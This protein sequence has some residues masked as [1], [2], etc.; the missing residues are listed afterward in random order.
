MRPQLAQTLR[1][2][3]LALLA[4]AVALGYGLLFL[5]SFELQVVR[6]DALR[7]RQLRQ[8]AREEVLPGQRG[9]VLDR[10]GV[11][12]GTSAWRYQ[13]LAETASLAAPE[14][15]RIAAELAS[16]TGESSARLAQRMA[17]E[18]PLVRLVY[19]LHEPEVAQLRAKQLPHLRI[20]RIRLRAY[21]THEGPLPP[22]APAYTG[23][24]G[25][26]GKGLSGVELA[27]D[28]VL[29]GRSH[30]QAVRRDGRRR[31]M[32]DAYSSVDDRTGQAVH[33]TLDAR[34][35]LE[36]ERALA[37]ALERT[38]GQAASL[39]AIDPRNGDVLVSAE[40][41]SFDSNAFWNE[42]P[43]RFRARAWTDEFE[44]GSTLKP[45]VAALALDAGVIGLDEEIDC[46]EGRLQI[47]RN[48]IRDLEPHG[49]LR[50]ADA[51]RVSSNIAA[52]RLGERLGARALV[53]G[54]RR[55]GFGQSRGEVFPGAA[56]GSVRNV[57]DRYPLDRA[58][59]AFGQGMRTSVVQLAL[60]G[61]ALASG[62]VRVEPRIALRVGERT[63][64]SG[65]T[66]DRVVS[67][68]TARQVLEMLEGV[69]RDGTG[70]AAALEHYAV[71]GK[72]GT[73]QKFLD[74]AY[75]HKRFVVS[76]L[77]IVPVDDPRLVVVVAID[78]PK[79]DASGGQ[80]AAPVFR[81]FA[82]AALR[83]LEVPAEGAP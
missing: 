22:L 35:Q 28:P 15:A 53:E 30:T 6:G 23:F 25:V 62:G 17:G 4:G 1:T 72:T 75:S 51:L 68:A 54:L 8:I 40:A 50:L 63:L 9:D 73:A 34:L 29:T 2:Q 74:G 78:E 3:R 48:A 65:R 82:W 60:A 81:E 57:T 70:R 47:G 19:G 46:G 16:I 45:F 43:A 11:L 31:R 77:G 24:V 37:R 55:F 83:T 59:L 27:F 49:A 76:F 61:A 13:V 44:P 64:P 7:E 69:V 41:P 10:N 79:R 67:E 18:A 20:E 56:D 66:D 52:A 71:A 58:T 38:G 14:R 26:E 33:L 12:L 32:L 21:P 36:A 42:D 39:V 80:G 5:R